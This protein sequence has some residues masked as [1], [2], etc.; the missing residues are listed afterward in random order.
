MLWEGALALLS[1]AGLAATAPLAG[2]AAYARRRYR[3]VRHPDDTF[4]VRT[5]DGWDLRVLHYMPRSGVRAHSEPVVLCHGLSANSYSLDLDERTSL[6]RHLAARGFHAFV[7]DLRGRPGSW[8]LHATLQARHAYTFEDHAYEDAPAILHAALART[9]AARAFWVGHSMGGMIGYVLAARERQRLAGLVTV[10]S[11]V[12]FEV[13]NTLATLLQLGLR[14]PVDPIP[15]RL[16]ARALACVANETFPPMADIGAL[17]CNIDPLTLRRAMVNAIVDLPRALVRQFAEWAQI[18][19]PTTDSGR[20]YLAEVERVRTPLL[21]LSGSVDRL[22][23]PASVRPGYELVRTN[24][25]RYVCIG[26]DGPSAGVCF[27]HGDLVL[28]RDAPQ[29]VFE[30]IAQWLQE[31]AT[32]GSHRTKVQLHGAMRTGRDLGLSSGL[33][34]G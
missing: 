1:G 30:P 23:P 20:N 6:A 5:R 4:Q 18:E 26:E 22:A 32:S 33:S 2:V 3:V 31:R 11:P 7:P 28:G 14:L 8:P 17:R 34:S 13:E 29:L 15:H 9:G 16:L 27:G 10:A 19:K 12:A 25:R 24:D 21:C